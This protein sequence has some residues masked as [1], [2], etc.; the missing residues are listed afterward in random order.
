MN[1]IALLKA[2]PITIIGIAL[3]IVGLGAPVALTTLH[4]DTTAPNVRIDTPYGSKGSPSATDMG[5]TKMIDG[6]VMELGAD[7]SL[8]I[9]VGN[10]GT[11]EKEFSSTDLSVTEYKTLNY[12]Y[13]YYEGYT[14][15]DKPGLVRVKWFAEDKAG[16]VGTSTGY[17]QVGT[18]DGYFEL[19]DGND[20]E[21]TRIDK[22][23]DQ[24]LW[25]NDP[26]LDVRFTATEDASHIGEIRVTIWLKGQQG[27]LQYIQM[28]KTDKEWTGSW[29][30]QEDGQGKGTYKI[31]GE[32]KVGT[33]YFPKMQMFVGMGEKPN[34]TPSEPAEPL[35]FE[36]LT[37]V[38][39]GLVVVGF[40]TKW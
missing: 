12:E 40:I 36:T 23:A 20:K 39:V 24:D 19:K 6:Y 33:D 1:P 15:P 3:V 34:P 30:M 29:N 28:S 9:D 32:I 37:Y 5:T 31:K 7:V 21:W 4:W 25:F 26:E 14:I 18:P 16:N 10:D 8:K 2:R 27:D 11:W 35:P 38:G 17:W 13:W 22:S